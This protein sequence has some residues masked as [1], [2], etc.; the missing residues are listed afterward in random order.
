MRPHRT[1]YDVVAGPGQ[2]PHGT[3]SAMPDQYDWLFGKGKGSAPDPS[4]PSAPEPPRAQP[5]ADATRPL[6]VEDR[7]IR[8]ARAGAAYSANSGTRPPTP[9]T[10]PPLAPTPGGMGTSSG[11]RGRRRLPRFKTVR[12]IVY[13]LLLAYVVSLVWVGLS[14]ANAIARVDWE[15]SGARPA[16]Q[17]GTNYLIV[18]SDSRKG[19]TAKQRKRLSTGDAAGQRTDTIK[20]LHTGSGPNLLMT[21]PRDSYVP[22]PGHGSTKI[23]AAFA[24]GGPQLLVKTI[25][26]DTG[27]HIDGYVEI[28]M[29]GLV[30]LVNGVGGITICPTKAMNDPLAGLHVKAGC[31]HAGGVKALAYSR[32]RHAQA[33]GDLGRGEAQTEVIGQIGK[34]AASVGTLANP[35]KLHRLKKGTSGISV[36]KGMS[37]VQMARFLL[38]FRSVSSGKALTCGV[39]ISDLYVHWDEARAKKMFSYLKADRTSNLPAGV[40]TPSGLP[41]SV[42]G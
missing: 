11:G 39:P 24:Y 32:S 15:P 34:K 36:G 13:V 3:V 28:G 42:T 14:V 33:L 8:R 19:L 10:P 5:G 26:Q 12:R 2:G 20:L 9:P 18:A 22:I 23:N 35:F 38:A 1:P 6:P 4:Q 41:K 16:D 40:C 25:E 7:D 37:T 31:Q 29:G 17:P 21:I 27:L 30:N